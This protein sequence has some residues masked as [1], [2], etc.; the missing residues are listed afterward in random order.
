[1]DIVLP[2]EL[3]DFVHQAVATGQYSDESAV[4]VEALRMLHR[5]EHFRDEVHLGVEQ[6]ER[7]EYQDEAGL[8]QQLEENKA[9]GR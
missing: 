1:M 8:E 7:G 3:S 6:L 5:R 2:A 9:K 4:I